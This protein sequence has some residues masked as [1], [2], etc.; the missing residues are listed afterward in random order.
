MTLLAVILI[1]NRKLGAVT[2]SMYI[3]DK[4]LKLDKPFMSDL[5]S[6]QP[7]WSK[8][9]TQSQTILGLMKKLLKMQKQAK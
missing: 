8:S 6:T 4:G 9:Q 1:R 5:Q 2:R 7:S 3:V